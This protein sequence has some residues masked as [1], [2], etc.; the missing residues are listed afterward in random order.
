MDFEKFTHR[1]QEMLQKSQALAIN[2]QHQAIEPG[3]L[4]LALLEN[5]NDVI[6]YLLKKNNLQPSEVLSEVKELFK[7]YNEFKKHLK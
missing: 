5:E 7:T 2:H 3:H 1:A 4:L 6:G